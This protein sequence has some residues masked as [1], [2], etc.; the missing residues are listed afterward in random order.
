M[1]TIAKIKIIKKFSSY[2]N[3]KNEER[4]EKDV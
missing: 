4:K 3:K 2:Q 1:N